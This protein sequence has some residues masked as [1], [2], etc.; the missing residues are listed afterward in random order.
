MSKH[1]EGPWWIM[2]DGRGDGKPWVAHMEAAAGLTV[3]SPANTEP[4][5]RV[6]GYLQPVEANTAL[7]CA[8]PDLLAACKAALEALRVSRPLSTPK[9]SNS[10]EVSAS[11][12]AAASRQ[13]SAAIQKAEEQRT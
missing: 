12:L 11:I 4:I 3:G 10:K 13:L 6:S 8:A 5:C 7:I 9:Q 2:N 1:T